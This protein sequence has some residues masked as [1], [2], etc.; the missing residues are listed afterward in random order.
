MRQLLLSEGWQL[1]QYDP[2]RT[3][4]E[5]CSTDEG[6]IPALVPGTVHQ[7]LIT[8]DRLP[9]PFVGLNERAAQ[10][11]GESDWLY[12]C[13]FELPDDFADSGCVALC[14]DGL[15]TIATVWLNGVEV[16]SSDNMFVPQRIQ[17]QKWLHPGQN[18]LWMRFESAQR[19][20]KEREAAHGKLHVWNGD[21]SRVYVRKAQ[22]HYGW[23]WGP[24][25]L[26]AGPWRAIRLEAYEARIAELH[27]P[28]EVAADLKSAVIP[29]QIEVEQV[30]SDTALPLGAQHAAHLYLVK[31]LLYAPD[32]ALV[33]AASVAVDGRMAQHQIT[34][35][36]PQLWWPNGYGA[37]PLYRLVVSLEQGQEVVDTRTIRLGLRRLVL[38]QEALTDEAGTTFLFE[39]NNTPVFCGGA[40]WIP[41]DS[42]TPRITPERYRTLLK[43]AAAANMAMIRI[44]GGGIYEDDIFYEICDEL[45]LLVWQDFMFA[46]GIYPAQDWFLTS[47]RAEAEAQIRRLRQHACIALWCGNNEDYQ[48]ANSLG[49]YDPALG[50]QANEQFPARQIY[51]HLLPEICAA[52]DPTRSYWPGSPYGGQNGND[53]TYGDRHVWDIWHGQ[54]APYQSYP[55][56]AGRFVSEFGMQASP[57]MATLES[58]ILPEDRYPGSRTL[59]HHNKA[60]GGPR[61]IAAYL[62]DNLRPPTDLESYIY[63]TQLMQTDALVSAY[64]GWR[65]RWA[66]PGRYSL[67]GALVWQLNDCWPVTSW[68][69]V[70]Y[71][72]R[73]KPAYYGI[74]RALA[75]L[76]I[77][78]ARDEEGAAVWVVNGTTS[79]VEAVVE[80]RTLTLMGE[81]LS[82][83][84]AQ[85]TLPPNATT[86]LGSFGLG[87]GRALVFAARLLVDGRVVARDVLWP[88]P[89]KYFTFPNPLIM[90]D[91]EGEE[92]LRL[93]S[94]RPAKGV[95]LSAGDGVEWSDNMLD[96]M[97]DDEQVIV[98]R[99]LGQR[100]VQVRWLS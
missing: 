62:T 37:Q 36:Q 89:L 12:R 38:L 56:Y 96:L 45:G 63:A 88:E 44:W 90:L 82:L 20:G 75:A 79:Q 91:L 53:P 48:I 49:L 22:Y 3:I 81:E 76:A 98:A 40:N 29:V 97:P 41:A 21:P 15:D 50:P 80:L 87:V 73:P 34:I 100:P 64:R 69:I 74:R 7:A 93:R 58:F 66:G 10:W 47:I 43:Q 2:G 4:D 57:A 67:A 18:E 16:L 13:R 78:M 71:G 23:D 8:A 19:H 33:S 99:G 42:F 31:L 65:R 46:C 55:K 94:A 17:I 1:S 83:E 9:D 6:W 30:G 5:A 26:T 60:E 52:L 70:D 61:R 54:M 14:C 39:V 27:C 92:T 11:V 86:E 28:I 32:G 59:D 72:L 95:W 68:A 77:G 24:T 25:L 35:E 84:R 51:E 85:I